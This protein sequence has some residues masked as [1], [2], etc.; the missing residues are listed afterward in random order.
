MSRRRQSVFVCVDAMFCHSLKAPTRARTR[1]SVPHSSYKRLNTAI[2]RIPQCW[3]GLSRS[4][5]FGCQSL[6]IRS[7]PVGI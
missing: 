5:P 2:G 3:P 4:T 1:P 7:C 6:C